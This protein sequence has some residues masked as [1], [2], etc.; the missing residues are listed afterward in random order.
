MGVQMMEVILN[1]GFQYVQR[2][3]WLTM[4]LDTNLGGNGFAYVTV[5]ITGF[6]PLEICET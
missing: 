4:E 3:I 1:L 2:M 5:R 6:H